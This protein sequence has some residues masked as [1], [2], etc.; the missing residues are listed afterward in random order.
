[1]WFLYFLL[2]ALSV[3]IFTVIVLTLIS[4]RMM[5]CPKIHSLEYARASGLE[6]NEFDEAYLDLPWEPISVFS[7][8]RDTCIAGLTLRSDIH[9][10]TVIFVH[11]ITWNRYGDYKYARG[12]TERGWN[13]VVFDLP[14]HGASPGGK[15][16]TPAFGYLEKWDLDAVVDWTRKHYRQTPIV[17]VGESMGAGTVL[18]YAPVGAPRGKSPEEWKIDAIIADC[19]YSSAGD[20][21]SAR[22]R[23]LHI[24]GLF[25]NPVCLLVSGLLYLLRGYT[26]DIISPKRAVLESPVPILFVHGSEDRYVPTEMSVSMAENRKKAGAGPAELL[27]VEGATHAKSIVVNPKLWFSKAFAFIDTYV[28]L[29]PDR[30]SPS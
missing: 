29:K 24:P 3:Y 15:L 4:Y 2:A 8:K 26:L 16:K 23:A 12:F 10:G 19:S 7:E 30:R 25:R 14:G 13:V 6:R 17:L 1:M 22:L 9:T 21:L 5:F 18:Q 27:I 11:G 28:P 20:E